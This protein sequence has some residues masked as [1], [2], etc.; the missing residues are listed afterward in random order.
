MFRESHESIYAQSALKFHLLCN[1]VLVL[2]I[3]SVSDET[4]QQQWASTNQIF[5]QTQTTLWF[6]AIYPFVTVNIVTTIK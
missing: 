3:Q 6:N 4:Q 1:K 2:W 5:Q